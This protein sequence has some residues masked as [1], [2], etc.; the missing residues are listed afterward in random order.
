M[1]QVRICPA[2]RRG[3]GRAHGYPP[4]CPRSGAVMLAVLVCVG[5]A[6]LLMLSI[7][8]QA[9]I[10][11]AEVDLAGRALQARWLAEAALDRAAARLHDDPDYRGEAWRLAADG[12]GAFQA[13]VVQIEV[14]PATAGEAHRHIRVQADYPDDPTYRVRVTKETTLETPSKTI[15]QR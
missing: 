3:A 11:R 1:R 7:L 12:S 10:R 8:Q 6:G 4:G 2:R 13:A 14:R 5:V 15:S 9:A